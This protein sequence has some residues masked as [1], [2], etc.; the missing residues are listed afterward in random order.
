MEKFEVAVKEGQEGFGDFPRLTATTPWLQYFPA[1]FNP[2]SI[3]WQV[4]DSGKVK[5]RPV[6][7]AGARRQARNAASTDCIHE[8]RPERWQVVFEELTCREEETCKKM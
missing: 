4:K 3:A 6:T 8:A 2:K 7:D 1:R 5:D